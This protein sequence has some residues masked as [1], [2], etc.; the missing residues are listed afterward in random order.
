MH[1]LASPDPLLITHAVIEE[2]FACGVPG[3]S[4]CGCPE[5]EGPPD[6]WHPGSHGWG[7]E[8]HRLTLR[9]LDGRAVAALTYEDGTLP[10]ALS[11]VLNFRKMGH[12]TELPRGNLLSIHAQAHVAR[13]LGYTGDL[14]EGC[15]LL[16]GASCGLVADTSLGAD[17]MVRAATV[18]GVLDDGLLFARFR[19]WFEEWERAHP[20]EATPP[21]PEDADRDHAVSVWRTSDGECYAR[22]GEDE[23]SGGTF[24]EAVE[25][26]F[27]RLYPEPA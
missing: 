1:P 14:R 16:N 22:S 4:L 9:S 24:P 7:A 26:L 25:R 8:R 17:E 20:P 21:Y 12:P 15:S 19:A 10:E 13:R 3:F 27:R 23:A 5:K 2:A 6:F 11:D 18:R